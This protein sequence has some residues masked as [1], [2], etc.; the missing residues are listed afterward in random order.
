MGLLVG[1]GLGLIGAKNGIQHIP[2]ILT[3]YLPGLGLGEGSA[4]L[5][6]AS[7]LGGGLGTLGYRAGRGVS[8]SAKANSAYTR[9]LLESLAEAPPR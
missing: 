3:H 8:A 9:K 4:A 2:D 1:T 6:G 5:L 7:V